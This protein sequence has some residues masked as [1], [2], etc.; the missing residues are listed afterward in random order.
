MDKT[1]KIENP[2]NKGNT[3]SVTKLPIQLA[4]GTA[5]TVEMNPFIAAPIPAICPIGCIAKALKFPNRKP[6]AKNCI[7]KKPTNTI[8]PGLLPDQ[9]NTTYK[10]EIIAYAIVAIYAIRHIP[11]LSTIRLFI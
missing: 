3:E 10:T 9:N 2:I 7:A 4:I 6:I 1:P 8:I 11:Y 5:I